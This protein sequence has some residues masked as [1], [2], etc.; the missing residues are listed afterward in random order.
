[1]KK[2][3]FLLLCS[4]LTC[5]GTWA[6]TWTAGVPI[7]E[8]TT[9]KGYFLYNI[10][11]GKFLTEGMD[12]GTH[13]TVDN[14]GRL[15]TFT[16]SG[17][18]YTIYTENANP[19]SNNEKSG[20]IRPDAYLDIE[21]GYDTDPA[22]KW[23]FELVELDGYTNLYKL[24]T[25]SEYAEHAAVEGSTTRYLWYNKA[26]CRVAIDALTGTNYDYWLIIPLTARQSANDYTYLLNNTDMNRPWERPGWGLADSGLTSSGTTYNDVYNNVG[27]QYNMNYSLTQSMSG[28]PHGKYSFTC[29]GFYRAG[30]NTNTSKD[31]HNAQIYLNST[32]SDVKNIL[33]EAKESSF[34]TVEDTWQTDHSVAIDDNTVFFPNSIAGASYW[35]SA[36]N[37]NNSVSALVVDGNISVGISKTTK[38][39]EDWT[40]FDN[41][42]LT[43]LGNDVSF[44]EPTAFTSGSS[45]TAG[46][47]YAYSVGSTGVY[48]IS[49]NAA[50]TFYYT[51]DDSDDADETASI[52]ISASG[53]TT[54][55][56][57]AG[58]TLYFKSSA[59]ATITIGSIASGDNVTSAYI[60]NPSFEDNGLSGWSGNDFTAITG[61][62]L[63][64][65]DGDTYVVANNSNT[66]S[67]T[68]T[69]SDLSEGKY[70]LS[71][72]ARLTIDGSRD[73]SN[74]TA[75]LGLGG[76]TTNIPNSLA[77]ATYYVAYEAEEG[78]DPVV[79][80]NHAPSW[81]VHYFDNFTLTYYTT[82]PDVDI[83]SL[84]GNLMSGS[85]RIE[86]NAAKTAYDASKTAANYNRLQ[87]AIVN[88]KVSIATYNSTPDDGTDLTAIIQNPSFEDGDYTTGWSTTPSGD[89]GRRENGGIYTMSGGAGTYV[90]N[91]WSVG[92]AITQTLY[93]LPAGAYKLTAVMATDAGATFQLTLG[94]NTGTA[95][96]IDKGTGVT[97][98]AYTY[99]TAAGNLN[100]SAGTVNNVWYKV[101]NF[102]LTYQPDIT[103]ADVIV[104][105]TVYAM[106]S[107]TYDAQGAA[108]ETYNG[109]KTRA[110]YEAVMTA[111]DNAKTSVAN[112]EEAL[113]I[114]NAASVLDAA[115]RAS[116]AANATVT[117][118]QSAYNART[119]TAVTTE[120]KTA[121]QTA[122]V[123]ATKAQTT[124]G[125]DWTTAIWDASFE[126]NSSEWTYTGMGRQGNDSFEKD[127]TYYTEVYEPNGTK[128]VTQTLTGMPAGVYRL[129]ATV[130]A[131]G[132]TSAK[133]SGN[134]VDRSITIK[135]VSDIYTVDFACD[136]NTDVTIGFEGVG[137][138]VTASWMCVDN[139][140]LT[141]LSASL[142]DL[143]A[144]EGKMKASVATAQETAVGAYNVNKTSANYNTASAAI[145]AA[146]ASKDAYTN[147]GGQISIMEDALA[148]S[149]VYDVDALTTL[150]TDYDNGTMT[151]ATAAGL[152]AFNGYGWHA[153]NN[154]DDI[155]MSPWGVAAET[156]SDLHV[157]TWSTEGAADDS[158]FRVPFYEYWTGDDSS[159]GAKTMTATVT[160]LT[161]STTYR[162]DIFARVR[163]TNGQTKV[164]E[165]I[166]M[167]VGSGTAVDL[168][169]GT[170]VGTTQFYAGHF[171]ATGDTDG[172]GELTI[173]INV[174]EGSNISWLSFRDVKYVEQTT[175][176]TTQI[177]NL[178]AA[179]TAAKGH[180][181]GF[182]DGEYAPYNNV[183]NI[184]LIAK[185]E[186][187]D[188]E[189]NSGA[190]YE[191]LAT[192]LSSATWNANDGEVNA[193]Y[194]PEYTSSSATDEERC[195]YALGWGL[196]G[197]T[198]AT[199]TRIIV[200]TALSNVGVYNNLEN[201]Q[202]LMTKYNTTYGEKDGYTLPLMANTKYYLTF[203]YG[204]FENTP[205]VTV[206]VTDPSDDDVSVTPLN[207][208]TPTYA[209]AHVSAANQ[210]ETYTGYFMTNEAGNY[211]LS[212]TKS[213]T[214]QQQIGMGNIVLKTFNGELT[215]GNV[216]NYYGAISEN[217]ELAPTSEA[218][219]VDITHAEFSGSLSANFT[220][221]ENGFIIATTAQR[222]AMDNPKNVVVD[223]TCANLVIT[224]GLTV[225]IPESLTTATS[226]TYTRTLPSTETVYGT[227]CLPYRVTSNETIQYYSVKEI[228][229]TGLLRL[230]EEST[231]DAG[232][233]AIFGKKTEGAGSITAAS[234]SAS[235][236]GT[237]G[238]DDGE[239]VKLVGTFTA[240]TI[241]GSDGTPAA[242]DCYY[243]KSNM[244]YQGNVSFNVT[245]Y[246]AYIDASGS[247][248][249]GA[250]P[251]LRISLDSETAIDSIKAIDE[252][253]S[254][255]DGK[256]LIGGKIIVVKKGKKYSVGGMLEK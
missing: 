112:Y 16:L 14:A 135:D 237:A 65:R 208:F 81:G 222:T 157:N 244:F 109:D 44:Y 141:L 82:L 42:K 90:F 27:E 212:I 228:T 248:E 132:V 174:A 193:I 64:N 232:V 26:D 183:A 22:A 224:D 140:H 213:P 71:V 236:S 249:G 2:K 219:V 169:A 184:A 131:R 34:Y 45:A 221:N 156:W 86:L 76:N 181:L 205:A 100:I 192:A 98:T 127:G 130:K 187:L 93:G 95:S 111:I 87:N 55:K 167:Q 177:S 89:T 238:D 220:G 148:E 119:L 85:A 247:G 233:P 146:Q 226:A 209:N 155:M 108:I 20:Y 4:V 134:G 160:G 7:A 8:A 241:N 195:I 68:Q 99:L 250:R 186:A 60:T 88:A 180:A 203:R 30:N 254:L 227:I 218:P 190:E 101:D 117:A 105:N 231:I 216:Q 72:N 198:N 217:T 73:G 251:T 211:V 129:T 107:D 165:K 178:T 243:I 77:A 51:L 162:V 38:V 200:G 3:L 13:A 33:D 12:W 137:T 147:A 139:F 49:S 75:T 145:V 17:G 246:R 5:V 28:M 24:S 46:T 54:M 6:Q 153:S 234:S 9:S 79:A 80:Y 116:Y 53:Y 225:T 52:A 242:E 62:V 63:T 128:S 31:T 256:Y 194:W 255:E 1:M 170:Q 151:D 94:G 57:T 66:R 23:T 41:F 78:A 37:Y 40:V 158:G 114:L 214:T 171:S 202:T 206:T 161:D 83:S 104:D 197:L 106:N 188:P 189:V 235:I 110:N 150:R 125:S 159:L 118:I 168:A 19:I 173:S 123:A 15:L 136:D 199:N 210:F 47:W 182:Q 120:Q 144:V 96:S 176:T 102:Q 229:G 121:C 36:G 196:A 113:G 84:T 32:T 124:A 25:L 39:N 115:G 154:I 245:P 138:G 175:P 103:A 18:K 67:L 191:E 92:T 252:A 164:A 29:Q 126:E 207:T 97:V 61:T 10:G 69:L 201:H 230:K 240:Q 74:P 43:Y 166:T 223:G 59:A 48:K 50:T 11:A 70:V 143:T 185:A 172:S 149:N 239:S 204:G 152:T 21:T 35:L 253:E 58:S 122:L 179:V 56:L 133:I 215:E 142:P 163:Q 91:T